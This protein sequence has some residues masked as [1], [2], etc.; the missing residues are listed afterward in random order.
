LQYN[1]TH[2]NLREIL[3]NNKIIGAISTRIGFGIFAPIIDRYLRSLLG[4]KQFDIIWI[5]TGAELSEQTMRWLRKSGL[6]IVNY[7]ADD[8][9]GARDGR[10]WKLYLQT[11]KYLDLVAVVRS[12][13]IREAY[14]RGAANVA[15]CFRSFDPIAHS[16]T[17]EFEI[18]DA[19][20]DRW[21]HEVL[22][23][24]TWMPERVDFIKRLINRGIPIAIYGDRWREKCQDKTVMANFKGTA[25]YG[26][27]YVHAIQFSKIAI[28]LVSEGNR[29]RHT[30]RSLEIPYIGGAVFCAKRTD[31][32]AR[33]FVDN[34]E[35]ALWSTAEECASICKRLLKA[36]RERRE[37]AQA[38]RQRVIQNRLS[39]D[40]V[41]FA[42]INILN[43]NDPNHD[44]VCPSKSQISART[45]RGA[46]A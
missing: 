2:I 1:V 27:D 5:D 3:P 8:P 36:D 11:L 44:Y 17:R 35:A 46:H 43:G 37:I 29:D 7:N 40:E 20:R 38:G 33:L 23:V 22:F 45:V 4:N 30:T 18:T 10:K 26:R 12:E 19:L 34:A 41:L 24:G 6:R 15:W 21:A 31:E 14:E 25:L 39:N 28:G 9:F 13:N 42:L 16:P 32:H